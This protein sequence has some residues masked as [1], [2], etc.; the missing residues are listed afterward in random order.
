M[1]FGG[2]AEKSVAPGEFFTSDEVTLNAEENE[3]LCLEMTYRGRE[4]PYHEESLLPIFLQEGEEWTPTKKMPLPGM[5]GCRR[6]VKKRIGL[7]GDSITQGCGTE[8]NSYTHYGARIAKILGSDY[9]FWDLGLGYG[10]ANDAASLGA[11]FYKAKQVDVITVCYGVNDLLQGFPVEQTKKD[12]RTLAENLKKEGLTVI[13]QTVPPFSYQG[14][15]IR[16]WHELNEYIQTELSKVA[17]GIFDVVPILGQGGDLSHMAKYG[18]HPDGEGH[19]VWSEALAPV[20]RT[21]L[22]A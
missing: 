4:L 10:R 7:I 21:V 16:R 8:P 19:K 5:I 13:L 1:S 14:D 15:N 18:D 20:L 3:F 11:W 2:K 22:E 17:D 9:S 6:T 12:M